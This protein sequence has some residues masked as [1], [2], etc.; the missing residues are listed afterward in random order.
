MEESKGEKELTTVQS[1]LTEQLMETP[2]KIGDKEIEDDMTDTPDKLREPR[3]SEIEE[4]KDDK[5][6]TISDSSLYKQLS[7]T[8]GMTGDDDME[9]ETKKGNIDEGIFKEL[10]AIMA[11]I[12]AKRKL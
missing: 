3:N 6:L 12:E 11:Q 1:S 5:E 10:E 8:A 7:E 2:L 4:S 9:E